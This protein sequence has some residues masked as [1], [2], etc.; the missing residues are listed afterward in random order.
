M[1]ESL[2]EAAGGVLWRPADNRAAAEV[3]V[4]HRPKYDDWS[5]A[6][7][8]LLAGEHPL[9]GGA[10]EV[11][12]ETGFLVRIGRPLGEVRYLKDGS[13]KR[14]RYWA[15]RAAGGGFAPN[16]EVDELRWLAPAEAGAWLSPD[17]DQPVLETFMRDMTPTVPVALV[18][19]AAAGERSAWTGADRDRPLVATGEEQASALTEV[20]AVYGIERVMSADVLRCIETVAPYAAALR[21][22]VESEP[23]LSETGYLDH[24][25]AALE[26]FLDILCGGRATAVCS[27]GKTIPDLL[28][29]ACIALGH[30]VPADAS[31]RKSGWWT[32]HMATGPVSRLVALERFD[33]IS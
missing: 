27:Q 14:V 5:I 32:L 18:R 16:A 29:R 17:R 33:P 26:R 7:G 1:A 25:D 19:H 8:K 15:M 12:E 3:A 31:V 22:T 24:P 20:F 13:P 6:K 2:I 10:R 9:L 28:S 30:P 23:L 21:L 4:V 11:E